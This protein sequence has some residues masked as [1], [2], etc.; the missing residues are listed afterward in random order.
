M[1]RRHVEP[2]GNII[3]SH[4]GHCLVRADEWRESERRIAEQLNGVDRDKNI[5]NQRTWT[6][7]LWVLEGAHTTGALLMMW[8]L[9]GWASAEACSTSAEFGEVMKRLQE[10]GAHGRII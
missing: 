7:E 5:Q 9:P 4:G 3:S 10:D 6:S 8:Q 1:G 2:L